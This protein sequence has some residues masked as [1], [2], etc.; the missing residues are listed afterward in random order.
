VKERYRNI[1]ANVLYTRLDPRGRIQI[2]A[3]LPLMYAV[4]RHALPPE[5]HFPPPDTEIPNQPRRTR[6]TQVE[7]RPL[8]QSLPV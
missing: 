7:D 2:T 6:S 5:V 1:R 4:A 8:L 3:E